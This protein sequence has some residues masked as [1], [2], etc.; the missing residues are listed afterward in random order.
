[1]IIYRPPFEA[2]LRSA[3]RQNILKSRDL[4]A[5]ND[6]VI[7]DDVFTVVSNLA[8]HSEHLHVI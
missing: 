1:M 5:P 6:S 3:I 7:L 4:L 2:E 8:Q